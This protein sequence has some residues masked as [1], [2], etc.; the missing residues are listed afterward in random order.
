MYYYFSTTEVTSEANSGDHDSSQTIQ[1]NIQ[2]RSM[3]NG[4]QASEIDLHNQQSGQ[5]GK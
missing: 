4:C 2:T 3:N 1:C 5:I